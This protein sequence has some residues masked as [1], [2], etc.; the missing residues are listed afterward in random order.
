MEKSTV[1]FY[2]PQAGDIAACYGRDLQS[3]II[4]LGTYWPLSPPGLRF[5]PSHVAIMAPYWANQNLFWFESTT[6]CQRECLW[7]GS[8]VD[9]VQMHDINDRVSDYQSGGG[10]VDIYRLSVP[11]RDHQSAIL[12]DLLM[13]QLRRGVRYDMRGAVSSGARI[14]RYLLNQFGVSNQRLFCSDQLSVLLMELGKLRRTNPNGF[15]PGR[16]LRELVR[17][18]VY[19][20]HATL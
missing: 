12:T 16:L 8:P 7:S 18:G 13:D 17:N 3:R 6:K 20:R 19:W 9:G 10:R 5:G 4:S 2:V 11:L 14:T 1:P 15:T